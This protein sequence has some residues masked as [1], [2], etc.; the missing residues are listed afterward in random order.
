MARTRAGLAVNGWRAT[1]VRERHLRRNGKI[2]GKL[3]RFWQRGDRD[4]ELGIW[5]CYP[6]V[7]GKPRLIQFRRDE[8]KAKGVVEQFLAR[9][10]ANKK[11]RA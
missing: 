5:H 4:M 7:N 6:Y 9:A 2:V 3:M 10:E 1:N 8:E 11:G